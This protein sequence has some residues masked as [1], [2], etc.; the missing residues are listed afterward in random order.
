[1]DSTESTGRQKP[2]QRYRDKIEDND[3]DEIPEIISHSVKD[4]PAHIGA[5]SGTYPEDT[6]KGSIDPSEILSFIEVGCNGHKKQSGAAP[7]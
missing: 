5:Q 6:F 2:D 4:R 3:E 1:M 7:P